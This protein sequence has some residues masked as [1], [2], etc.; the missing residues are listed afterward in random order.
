MTTNEP[1]QRLL[2]AAEK[3]IYANGIN[4]TGMEAIVSESGVARKTIYRHFPT[5]EELVAEVLRQRDKRWMNWFIA[6]T[7]QV[8]DPKARILSSFDAL[9]EWFSTSDFNGCAF[10]NAA[11]ECGSASTLIGSVAKE[12][13]VNLEHY[14]G[15]LASEYGASDPYKMASDLLL[16]IE[17]AITVAKVMGDKTA[18]RNAQHLAERLFFH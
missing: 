11:G 12:H 4:A 13:K 16:L 18:A 8:T 10:I 14:L 7:S 3:L 1:L 15:Q 5:K 9:E 6:S 17:G 2:S